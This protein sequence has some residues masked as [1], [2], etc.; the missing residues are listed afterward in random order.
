[1]T[2][3]LSEPGW[4]VHKSDV[5]NKGD[6][7][8]HTHSV[9]NEQADAGRDSRTRVTR[10]NSLARTGTGKMFIFPVQLATSRIGNLTRLI[11]TLLTMALKGEVWVEAITEGGRRFMASWRK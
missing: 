7:N 3:L 8:T 10:P 4:C 11:Q 2:F 9:E 5:Q 6:D 1:M